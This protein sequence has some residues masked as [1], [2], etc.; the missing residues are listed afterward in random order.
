MLVVL[1]LLQHFSLHSDPDG[2]DVF[3]FLEPTYHSYAKVCHS[4]TGS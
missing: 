1:P 4:D 2:F 3:C